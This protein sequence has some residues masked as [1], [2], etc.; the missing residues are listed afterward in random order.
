MRKGVARFAKRAVGCP[1]TERVQTLSDF[2]SVVATTLKGD[3]KY[4]FRGHS[5]VSWRLVP[6]AL[7][8]SER[9]ERERAL[10]LL[11]EFKRVA[12]IKQTRPP[13]DDDD[14]GW[15][16]VAQHYGLPTRLLDWTESPLIALYFACEGDQA[17]GLVF[18]L[19]PVD[20]NRLSYRHTA[21]I[22]DARND[23]QIIRKYFA[24]G[25]AVNKR[26]LRTVAVN[27]IWNSERLMLQ[28][29]VF[30]LHGSRELELP[31]TT[32]SLAAV[33]IAREIKPLLRSELE[34]VGIDELTIFPELEHAC[35]HLRRRARLG[36][37]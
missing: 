9:A 36:V 13:R 33:P 7:R 29:G 20:L 28:K 8:Y 10:D 21:R 37:E 3:T 23:T 18:L 32:P 26:G 15:H 11:T 2:F 22:L 31:G 19:N 27:P 5:N 25:G 34:S 12:E 35:S 24:L 4:W 17:D 6:S 1:I 16:Q 14:L 30:T